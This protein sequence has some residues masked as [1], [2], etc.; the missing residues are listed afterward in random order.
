MKAT[1]ILTQGDRQQVDDTRDD[2][3]QPILYIG[4]TLGKFGHPRP[5]ER[6]VVDENRPSVSA[7]GN[8]LLSECA[9]R[10]GA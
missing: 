5:L 3:L 8:Q 7:I 9:R 4:E 2:R 1:S 6:R 10:V